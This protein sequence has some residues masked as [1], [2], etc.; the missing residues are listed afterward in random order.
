MP[1]G[2][3]PNSLKALEE[4][5]KKNNFKKN[6]ANAV[7]AAEK[8]AA[9]R[10]QKRTFKEEF[11][12]ELSVM[13]TQTDRRGK[14]IGQTTVKNAITKKAVQKALRGDLEALRLIRDTIGEKPVETIMVS[15][16]DSGVISEVERMVNDA[17]ASGCVPAEPAV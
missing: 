15:E 2:M 7:R 11:E 10:A 9:V 1:R 16:V 3:H 5:R 8:S 13:I 14:V 4:H 12:A 6:T 17:A